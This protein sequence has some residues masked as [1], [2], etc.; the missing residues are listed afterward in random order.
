[1]I[2]LLGPSA[3]SQ[4]DRGN[5]LTRLTLGDPRAKAPPIDVC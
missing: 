3:K 1:M 5:G 4:T 2:A